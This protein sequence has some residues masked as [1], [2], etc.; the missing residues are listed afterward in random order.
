MKLKL[1]ID[2]LKQLIPND[3]GRVDERLLL[4]FI[5]EQ[6]SVQ[7]KNEFNQGRTIDDVVK[8]SLS[9][10]MN[11]VSSKL[12]PIPTKGVFTILKSSKPIPR[13]IDRHYEDTITEI[14]CPEI[15]SEPFNYVSFERAKYVG[16]GIITSKSIFAFIYNDY[17]YLKTDKNPKI[18]MIE[19]VILDGVF[20]KPEE[21]YLFEN[22]DGEVLQMD[23][24]ISMHTWTYIKNNIIND[25]IFG[26][27][28]DKEEGN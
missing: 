12:L 20:E 15:F 13:P 1:Y 4:Q 18:R 6:R 5:N 24:P 3:R 17:L 2:E 27:N 11:L 25:S 16:N 8:Q 7:L 21:A 22:V 28:A 14:Y 9:I 19:K 23:Y 10:D 26:V